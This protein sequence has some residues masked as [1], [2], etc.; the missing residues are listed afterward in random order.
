MCLLLE[1][2]RSSR[3]HQLYYTSA[4]KGTI[5]RGKRFPTYYISRIK[6]TNRGEHVPKEYFCQHESTKH[7]WWAT[8]SQ[9]RHESMGGTWSGWRKQFVQNFNLCQ[10]QWQ[11][12]IV[13]TYMHILFWSEQGFLHVWKSV[14]THGRMYALIALESKF[15]PPLVW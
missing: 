6:G 12:T 5:R 15:P 7:S 10:K 1:S 8:H 11:W 9:R 13:C 4:T 2:S 3:Y 14:P